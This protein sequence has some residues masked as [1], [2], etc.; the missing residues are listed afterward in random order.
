M[1]KKNIKGDTIAIIILTIILLIIILGYYLLKNNDLMSSDK[2]EIHYIS[3]NT[4]MPRGYTIESNSNGES[5]NVIIYLGPK[6]NPG[7]GIDVKDIRIDEL[8]NVTIKVTTTEPK[9]SYNYV[10][11][12]DY[13]GVRIELKFDPN[14]INVIDLTNNEEL[15]LQN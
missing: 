3:S 14:N 13:P 10:Q 7:Y 15:H 9:S 4:E 11:V 6:P 2:Y 12:I 1:T 8:N 5:T